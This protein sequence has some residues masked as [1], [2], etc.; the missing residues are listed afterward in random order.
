MHFHSPPVRQNSLLDDSLAQHP[1]VAELTVVS[2][3]RTWLRPQCD[4]VRTRNSWRDVL[5]EAGMTADGLTYF[6]MLMRALMRTTCRPLDM[7]CRCASDLAK[8]EASLLQTIAL[9]Q[10]THS[11]AAMQLLND[12]LPQP[13]VSG[14]LKI[15]RWF[16][17]SLL[18]AGIVIRVRM[19]RVTYMH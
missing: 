7:R 15:A 17:I 5:S 14:M 11:Q 13:A 6:D 16:A 10:K 2:A 12:W 8:D 9:L 18:D 4:A 3:V 19:R 1:D